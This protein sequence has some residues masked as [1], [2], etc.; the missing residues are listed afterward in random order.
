MTIGFVEDISIDTRVDNLSIT[1][2]GTNYSLENNV[3]ARSTNGNGKNLTIDILTIGG[4][5]EILTFSINNKGNCYQDNDNIIIIQDGSGNDAVFNIDSTS[6]KNGTNYNI[7]NDVSVTGNGAGLTINILT[8]GEN[9]IISTFNINNRGSG[10]KNGEFIIINQTGSNNDSTFILNK[11]SNYHQIVYTVVGGGIGKDN[12]TQK[13]VDRLGGMTKTLST[14]PQPAIEFPH[15]D[16]PSNPQYSSSWKISGSTVIDDFTNAKIEFLKQLRM[17]RDML[18]LE[19]DKYA[20][21]AA[22][23]YKKL[24]DIQLRQ[25]YLRDIT[26]DSAIDSATTIDDLSSI[27]IN[28]WTPPVIKNLKTINKYIRTEVDAET[29]TITDNDEFIGVIHTPT[30]SVILTLPQISTIEQ[31]KYIIKDEGGNAS[32]NNITINKTGND[33]IDDQTSVVINTDYGFINLYH[34]SSTKWFIY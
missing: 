29:Y 24:T 7:E 30:S 31:M 33:T 23:Q 12:I 10:Y 20:V 17:Q 18:L 5:G 19:T 6:L 26:D 13:R 27:T 8:V 11:T 3:I 34:D 1:S 32:I 22:S 15:I 14:Y 28:S 21:E 9:G 4:N 16:L 25:I 2:P